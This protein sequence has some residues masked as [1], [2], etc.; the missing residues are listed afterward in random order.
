MAEGLEGHGG[1]IVGLL[2]LIDQHQEAVEYELLVAGYRL[3]DLG[4]PALSW[5]DLLVLMHR[6]LSLPHNA[7]AEAVDGHT[8][9]TVAEQLLA[10][11]VDV[12]EWANWQRLGKRSAPKPKRVPRPWEK[13]ASKKYGKDPIPAS[14]F[15]AWWESRSSKPEKKRVRRR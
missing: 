2:E 7:V 12:L 10:V 13:S 8:R 11:I 5:R 9:W 4:T 1:G 14:Q 3:D 6:W 15:D